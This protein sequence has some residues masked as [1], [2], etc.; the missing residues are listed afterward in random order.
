MQTKDGQIT[1][2]VGFKQNG[3][4]TELLFNSD[5]Q[6]LNREGGPQV[7]SGKIEYHQLPPAVQ[8]IVN[9]RVK[10]GDIND[11]DRQVKNGRVTYE[12]GFKDNG[13]QKELL[14]SENGRILSDVSY[15]ASALGA[16]AAR[17]SGRA[18]EMRMLSPTKVQLSS[19]QK[20]ELSEVPP[21]AAQTIL[22][23]ANGAKIEDLEV[24]TWNNM[25]VYQAA[26]KSE[27]KHVEL[28]VASNGRVVHNP[29]QDSNQ[30][31]V[32]GGRRNSELF[33]ENRPRQR[34]DRAPVVND[35]LPVNTLVALNSSQVIGSDDLPQAVQ[36]AMNQHAPGVDFQNI[37]RGIWSDRIVYQFSF[38]DNGRLQHLQLDQ[39]GKLVHDTRHPNR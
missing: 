6:L 22:R 12:V 18:A 29:L 15:D 27:G 30:T 34:T 2:E 11:I 13:E 7:A 5:G 16:P 38:I 26:F 39:T 37:H 17:A 24:G 23:T 3:Q 21:E 19:G 33:P 10:Q 20:V 28:Q 35:N 14:L 8:Q 9:T 36:T 32:L 31:G 25:R 1:Y 4:H